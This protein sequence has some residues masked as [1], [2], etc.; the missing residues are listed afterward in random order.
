MS[1]DRDRSGRPTLKVTRLTHR[2]HSP[3]RNSVVQQSRAGASCV[4]VPAETKDRTGDAKLNSETIQ[5]FPRT[6]R[7]CLWQ[8]ERAVDGGR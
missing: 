6:F 4:I 5:V 7:A 1:V 8:A 2:R 3:N